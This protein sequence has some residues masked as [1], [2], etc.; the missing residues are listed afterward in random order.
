[1]K[2][3]HGV[4]ASRE[5]VFSIFSTKIHSYLGPS[6]TSINESFRSAKKGSPRR[7]FFEENFRVRNNKRLYEES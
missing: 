1:V 6:I 3:I 2:L 7:D 5:S 4:G